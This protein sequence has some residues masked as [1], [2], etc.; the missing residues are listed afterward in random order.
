[1][2]ESKESGLQESETDEEVVGQVP[3][4][5]RFKEDMQIES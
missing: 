1:V 2:R 3:V 5:G 4:S